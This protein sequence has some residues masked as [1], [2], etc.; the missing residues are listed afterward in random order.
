MRTLERSGKVFLRGHLQ[1]KREPRATKDF[2]PLPQRITIRVFVVPQREQRYQTAGD[3][4]WTR[5]RL[6]IRLSR[7]LAEQDPRYGVLLLVHE[8][9]EAMLCRSAGISTRQVD[10]FD[11]AFKGDGE[12][13]DDVSAPYHHQHRMAEVVERALAG[14]L[15]VKWRQYTASW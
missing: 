9:V 3:W 2:R 12:P 7:E 11:M 6:E 5:T 8:L 10:V 4:T 1:G 13:G 15:G 14:R